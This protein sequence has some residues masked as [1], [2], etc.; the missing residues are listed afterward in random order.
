MPRRPRPAHRVP[1][2]KKSFPE[3]SKEG[4]EEENESV[5][6]N[7][8]K[9]RREGE[10]EDEDEDEEVDA[11]TDIEVDADTPRVAQ[12]L[13]DEDDA[14]PGRS[15][16][17]ESIQKVSDEVRLFISPHNNMLKTFELQESQETSAYS[18]SLLEGKGKEKVGWSIEPRKDI[19][20]RTN[21]NA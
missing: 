4:Y 11:E 17:D 2:G 3:E 19:P 10:N 18:T 14:L 16:E 21:K 12:W 8:L 9:R 7:P 13:D 20:K 15:W 5:M 6:R 1:R